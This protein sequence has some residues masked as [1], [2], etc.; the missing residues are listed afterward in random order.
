MQFELLASEKFPF[1]ESV[2]GCNVL[3]LKPPEMWPGLKKPIP[4]SSIKKTPHPVIS[5]LEEQKHVK[6]MG[7]TMRLGLYPCQLKKGSHS[8]HLYG[9]NRIEERHRHRYEFNNHYKKRLAKAGLTII[10]ECP[11]NKL[12]EIVER[13]DHPFFVGVQFHPE[14]QSRPLKPHPLFRGFI[15]AALKKSLRGK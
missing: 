1:S 11:K 7:G 14:F 15:G 2:S 8:Y 5:L 13:N 4:Q 12:P 6:K 9:R 3:L 10:G